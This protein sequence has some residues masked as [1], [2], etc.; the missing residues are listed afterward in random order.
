MNIGDRKCT[1]ERCK[2]QLVPREGESKYSFENRTSCGRSCGA[3]SRRQ[4]ADRKNAAVL[5]N[6]KPCKWCAKDMT[7]KRTESINS[8]L[9]REHCTNQCASNTRIKN[10]RLNKQKKSL[11]KLSNIMSNMIPNLSGQVA[12]YK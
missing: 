1:N 6:K 8:F 4:E 9:K 10:M 11:K 7:Q 12:A 5:A 3:Q 2:K